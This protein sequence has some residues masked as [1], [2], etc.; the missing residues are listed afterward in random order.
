MYQVFAQAQSRK[1]KPTT[2][3]PLDLLRPASFTHPNLC[4]FDGSDGAGLPTLKFQRCEPLSWPLCAR[5]PAWVQLAV[6]E[7]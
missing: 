2:E 7:A 4:A 1:G 6:G 3:L 5:P